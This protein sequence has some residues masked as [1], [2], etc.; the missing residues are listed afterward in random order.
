MVLHWM[1]RFVRPDA[2]WGVRSLHWTVLILMINLALTVLV[3]IFAGM[4]V[5]ARGGESGGQK[6]MV[7]G[8]HLAPPKR[9]S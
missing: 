2:R 4:W 1:G 7:Y 6:R 3:V 5:G 8:P 9:E